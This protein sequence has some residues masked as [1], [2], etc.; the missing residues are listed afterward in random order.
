M[1]AFSAQQAS[2][3]KQRAAQLPGSPAGN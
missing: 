2:Q 3:Q 1:Q